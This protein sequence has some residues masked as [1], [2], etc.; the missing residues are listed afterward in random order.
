MSHQRVATPKA[1]LDI[2]QPLLEKGVITGTNQITGTG[3]LTTAST[4]IQLF[5]NKPNNTVTIGG[6]RQ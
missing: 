5:D 2:I 3:L 4:V 6:N 1:Y